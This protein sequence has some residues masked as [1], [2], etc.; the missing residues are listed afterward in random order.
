VRAF[1]WGAIRVVEDTT[2]REVLEAFAER[3]GCEDPV[4][5]GVSA[6][7]CRVGAPSEREVAE[8]R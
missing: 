5:E 6:V 2:I 3:E 7:V 1:R 4:Q 8:M